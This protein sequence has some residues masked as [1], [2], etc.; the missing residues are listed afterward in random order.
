MPINNSCL[1]YCAS[2]RYNNHIYCIQ[3]SKVSRN[4]WKR[5]KSSYYRYPKRKHSKKSFSRQRRLCVQ[6]NRPHDDFISLSAALKLPL[7]TLLLPNSH[8]DDCT[9]VSLICRLEA[10][11]ALDT[12]LHQLIGP[13]MILFPPPPN[14]RPPNYLLTHYCITNASSRQNFQ[15]VLVL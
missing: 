6:L 3:Y 12:S 2:V 5:K 14:M 13:V 15:P 7:D 10:I 1:S 11:R 9:S 8:C 4:R